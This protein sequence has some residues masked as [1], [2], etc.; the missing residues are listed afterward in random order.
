MQNADKYLTARIYISPQRK[1]RK[2]VEV[3][4]PAQPRVFIGSHGA[5]PHT[6][7]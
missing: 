4:F 1:D 2:P 5:F 6:L 7:Q 3:S